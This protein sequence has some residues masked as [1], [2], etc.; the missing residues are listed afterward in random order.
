MYGHMEIIIDID[1]T[2]CEELPKLQRSLAKPMPGSVEA[3][4]RLVEEGHTIILYSAR[5]WGEFRMTE[6]WLKR[7]RFKYNRLILGKPIGD[8]WIDDRAIQFKGNWKEII[9][10][11]NKKV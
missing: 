9:K 1:G 8:L 6:D 7:N 10:D 5:E 11:L 4:N 2:L 3:V